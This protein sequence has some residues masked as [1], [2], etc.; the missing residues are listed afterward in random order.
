MKNTGGWHKGRLSKGSNADQI[1]EQVKK[2]G[3]VLAEDES[4]PKAAEVA[5]PR[6]RPAS[7]LLPGAQRTLRARASRG[8]PARGCARPNHP[9]APPFFQLPVLTPGGT[10]QDEARLALLNDAIADRDRI[11]GLFVSLWASHG[12]G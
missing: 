10:T 8:P 9:H 12:L 6:P 2:G 11:E 7:W 1:M 5:H 3:T 4:A